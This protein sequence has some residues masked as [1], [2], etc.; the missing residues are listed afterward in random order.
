MNNWNLVAD[1]LICSGAI[2]IIIGLILLTMELL[3]R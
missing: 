2:F 1:T 3:G